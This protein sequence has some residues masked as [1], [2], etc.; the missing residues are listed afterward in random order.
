[1]RR[2]R[3]RRTP[4]ALEIVT[5]RLRL[6]PHVDGDLVRLVEALSDWRVSEWLEAPPWPYAPA[7]GRA[8][9]GHVKDD[10]ADGPPAHFAV[11]ARDDDRL[12][13]CVSLE[14]GADMPALGYWYHPDAWGDGI[15]TEAGA[16]ML[17]HGHNALGV[18]YVTSRTDPQNRASQ[19]VLAKLGFRPAGRRSVKPRTRHGSDMVLLFELTLSPPRRCAP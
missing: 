10:H 5:D 14:G 13:G 2:C 7:D 8:W 18:T 6:R 4:D 19:R 17:D 11:A 16:A 9:I 15:A 3:N 12:L 1:M